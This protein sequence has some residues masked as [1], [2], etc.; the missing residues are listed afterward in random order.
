MTDLDRSLAAALRALADDHPAAPG[1]FDAVGARRV[2]QVR[3]RRA[4]TTLGAA[5]AAAAVVVAVP[6]LG[7]SR[8]ASG[9]PAIGIDTAQ[10]PTF[11][12]SGPA[13]GDPELLAACDVVPTV[14]TAQDVEGVTS[15]YL[16]DTDPVRVAGDGTWSERVVRRAT[17]DTGP[18]LATLHPPSGYDPPTG[19]GCR[20]VALPQF[21][22]LLAGPDGDLQVGRP[23]AWAPCP[24]DASQQ[25]AAAGF[26]GGVAR[27]RLGRIQTE[28]EAVAA[29]QAHAAELAG[30][31]VGC[32]G[33]WK[34][35]ASVEAQHPQ[36]SPR[37]LT[38]AD[39]WPATATV[40]QCVMAVSRELSEPDL[41]VGIFTS[42]RALTAAEVTEVADGLVA[43]TQPVTDPT[44][45]GRATR[46]VVLTASAGGPF[47]RRTARR[48]PARR[49][50][51]R[52]SAPADP[53]RAGCS[54]E[55]IAATWERVS[56]QGQRDAMWWRGGDHGAVQ[57]QLRWR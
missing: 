20:A 1:L 54:P 21:T 36:P 5:A 47:V 19:Q 34:D 33:S 24:D 23:F 22:V 37:G 48:L 28:A 31:A 18:V 14:E 10:T 30:Q 29:E 9:G 35:M 49:R 39:L 25:V 32:S 42:G 15:V 55:T 46:F 44:C 57:G 6:A 41:P 52:L 27:A 40:R 53:A 4:W 11:D 3:R 17:A 12:P 51:T 16:C 43:S 38:A 56:G 7:G 50:L 26:S 8:F 2:R 13:T 45:P